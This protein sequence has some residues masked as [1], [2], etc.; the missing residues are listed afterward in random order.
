VRRM[1]LLMADS[2]APALGSLPRL[3]RTPLDRRRSPGAATT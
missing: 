3:R 1:H 2:N